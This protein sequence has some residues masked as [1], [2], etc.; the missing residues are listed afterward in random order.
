MILTFL[1][2]IGFNVLNGSGV[3]RSCGAWRGNLGERRSR[4]SRWHNERRRPFEMIYS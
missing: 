2:F 1:S 3:M 4:M